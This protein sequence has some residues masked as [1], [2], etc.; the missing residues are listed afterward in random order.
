MQLKS[1]QILLYIAACIIVYVSGLAGGSLLA[2]AVLLQMTLLLK[3]F[4]FTRRSQI[5]MFKLFLF[6]VPLFFFW[7]ATHSFVSIYS[8][9][10]AFFMAFSAGVV[11]LS[12]TFV[13]AFQLIFSMDYLA[14]SEFN[15]SAAIQNAFNE[16]RNHYSELL[17]T[18][19]L[20]FVLS[21]IPFLHEDWK[22][23]FALTAT[24]AYLNRS[25]LMRAFGQ[26]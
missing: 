23:V 22:L 26:T 4:E 18:T 13:L 14:R 20:I 3:G 19:L 21:F 24:L 7:G 25:Q 8:A 11:A 6:S 17:K 9:E 5:A 15:V 12:L 2:I 1:R 16:I 10:G